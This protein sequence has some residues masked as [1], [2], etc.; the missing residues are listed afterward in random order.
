M[1]RPRLLVIEDSPT[2]RY[3]LERLLAPHYS[4]EAVGSAEEGLTALARADDPAF[5]L[6]LMDIVLPG[7]DGFAATRAIRHNPATASIPIVIC[8]TKNSE[9]D[10]SWGLRLGAAWYVTK[11]IDG[12]RLLAVL[13]TLLSTPGPEWARSLEIASRMRHPF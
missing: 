10:I 11:P 5:A 2:E 12:P 3:L 9:T 1:T 8:T 6:V 13:H 7:L 4:M